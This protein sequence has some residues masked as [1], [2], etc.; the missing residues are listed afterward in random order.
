MHL[1]LLGW[2]STS[3][4]YQLS[5]HSVHPAFQ[6]HIPPGVYNDPV[7][8]TG[9]RWALRKTRCGVRLRATRD[10]FLRAWT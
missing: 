9:V 6:I 3:G 2:K 1:Q 4:V 7:V 8:Q 10:V 5:F